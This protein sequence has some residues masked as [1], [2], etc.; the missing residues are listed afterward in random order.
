MQ[1][2]PGPILSYP[3]PNFDSHK[4]IEGLQNWTICL[5]LMKARDFF[6]N[7]AFAC[8][9]VHKEATSVEWYQ[10]IAAQGTIDIYILDLCSQAL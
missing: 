10:F 4:Y 1:T 7:V 8:D 3:G 2:L 5:L 6:Q 9:C